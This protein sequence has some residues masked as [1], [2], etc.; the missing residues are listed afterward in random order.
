MICTFHVK[1]DLTASCLHI[2]CW[3]IFLNTNLHIWGRHVCT[4]VIVCTFEGANVCTNVV[5]CTF[6]GENVC[7]NVGV[8]TFVVVCILH[9]STRAA[10]PPPP[11]IFQK[12]IH[13]T[14]QNQI[15]FGQN[16]SICMQAMETNI[17]TRDTSAHWTKL[18]PYAYDKTRNVVEVRFNDLHSFEY[19]SN[20]IT[21]K[22]LLIINCF[23]VFK[24]IC[25]FSN[26]QC[27]VILY[28]E[29]FSVTHHRSRNYNLQKRDPTRILFL[30]SWIICIHQV[31]IPGKPVHLPFRLMSYL[32]GLFHWGVCSLRKLGTMSDR[33]SCTID[34]I[35]WEN[36]CYVMFCA[37]LFER[38]HVYPLPIRCTEI[39]QKQNI[40]AEF[41]VVVQFW[42]K[43]TNTLRL[44]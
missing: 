36:A 32:L 13:Q 14:K 12:A 3:C 25:L 40:R 10:A 8:C 44:I 16:H 11:I 33:K 24:L 19:N 28:P 43:K 15:I 9:G 27:W 38:M 20:S 37:F 41:Q 34:R 18:V 7:T 26:K 39:L 23:Y 29:F 35:V 5:V 6:E 1:I 17:R 31:D 21:I 2:N 22:T 4:N 30:L 42:R